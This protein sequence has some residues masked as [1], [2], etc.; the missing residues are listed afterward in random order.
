MRV[1]NLLAAGTVLAGLAGLCSARADDLQVNKWPDDVPCSA[2]TNN[3]DGTYT[4]QQNVV[5]GSDDQAYTITAGNVFSTT[6]EYKVWADKC[7]S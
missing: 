4:L 1:R 2:L 5:F 6:D 7:G 3:N